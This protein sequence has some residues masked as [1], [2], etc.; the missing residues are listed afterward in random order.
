MDRDIDNK[1]NHTL[2]FL[3]SKSF[4]SILITGGTGLI[5]SSIIHAIDEWNK[6]AVEPITIIALVRHISKAKSMFGEGTPNIKYIV[7]DVRTADFSGYYPDCIVHCANPTSS[8][9]FVSKPVETIETAVEGTKHVLE[10][11]STLSNLKRFI[12]LST[13]EIYGTPQTDEVI[14]ETH[15]TNID[16]MKVRSCYPTSKRMCENLCIAYAAEYKL[17]VNILRLT[18]TFGPGV[19][20]YDERVF[21]DFARCVIEGRDIV[22]KTRGE[23]KRSYLHTK[24]A[25]SAIF[26]IMS[27]NVEG[28][29]FNVANKDTYCSIRE[30][31]RMVAE[32]IA[33][34]K[35]A[36]KIEED[37]NNLSGFAPTLHMNLSTDKLE[38]LGWTACYG[39]EDMYRNMIDSM[40]NYKKQRSYDA[41][42]SV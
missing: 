33:G 22:L 11:A 18:Q 26:I 19:D 30:M 36:V 7:G 3:K 31:A 41:I 12:Y 29:A 28:E 40:I 15:P 14:H 10:Y 21:A 37:I 32:K 8:K 42:C 5:G 6:G 4:N 25:V 34:G 23:T 16:T 13:M 38:K 1:L 24:D 17:P 2:D 20:Y 35:I 27:S 9:L 39:L